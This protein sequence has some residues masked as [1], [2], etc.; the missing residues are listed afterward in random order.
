MSMDRTAL[1]TGASRGIGKRIAERLVNDGFFVVGTSTT[2]A[3]AKNI[4]GW[5]GDRGIGLTAQV[6]D[7]VSVDALFQRI[8][9]H[10]GDVSVLV[11]NAGITR[12]NLLVRMS[13]DEW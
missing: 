13:D 2:E 9:E 3:G 7:S 10:C 11:N 1:I 4:E 8:S 6:E 12:D 5:L